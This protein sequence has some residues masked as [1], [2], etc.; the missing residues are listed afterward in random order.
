MG[1]S[2][3]FEAGIELLHRNTGHRESSVR[4]VMIFRNGV[5]QMT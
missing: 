5:L 1:L 4:F 3:T 2:K